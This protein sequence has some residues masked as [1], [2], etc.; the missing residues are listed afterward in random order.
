MWLETQ[1]FDSNNTLKKWPEVTL[2]K[3]N[4]EKRWIIDSISSELKKFGN[5][6]IGNS[7][8]EKTTPNQEFLSKIMWFF[9][10]VDIEK[11]VVV[12]EAKDLDKIY[13]IFLPII[14]LKETSIELRKWDFIVY[15]KELWTVDIYPADGNQKSW[16]SQKP[17]WVVPLWNR[18]KPEQKPEDFEKIL[19]RAEKSWWAVSDSLWKF[20]KELK[21]AHT[22][23]NSCWKAVRTLLERFWFKPS[24]RWNWNQWYG[25]MKNDSRFKYVEVNSLDEIPAWWILTFSWKWKINWKAHWSKM[26]QKY[27]HVEIKWEGNKYHSFYESENPG[28]SAKAPQFHNNFAKWKE[29]TWFT[30]V[31][32]PVAKKR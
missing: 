10:W 8:N 17:T 11:W 20:V 4:L 18:K 30:W 9:N 12:N 15:N 16:H 13:E 23:N 32:V 28:G 24:P 27:W 25:M 1:S 29:A 22:G 3:D 5:D 6:I 7:N 19:N 14:D 21:C 26:N 31:F 2:P